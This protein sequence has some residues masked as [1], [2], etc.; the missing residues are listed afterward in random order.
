MI[1]DALTLI[2]N[3]IGYYRKWCAKPYY[4]VVNQ[5]HI[6]FIWKGDILCKTLQLK[7]M[8]SELF[9]I[10]CAYEIMRLNLYYYQNKKS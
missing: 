5:N 7:N 9:K 8:S 2:D 10:F 4:W 3:L 1:F 6:L